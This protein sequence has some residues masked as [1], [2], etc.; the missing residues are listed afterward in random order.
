MPT[1]LTSHDSLNQTGQRLPQVQT[2][3]DELG[4]AIEALEKA[5]E[6][7]AVRY[8]TVM[9]EVGPQL[10]VPDPK[11]DL[12]SLVIVAENIREKSQKIKLL[13]ETVQSLEQRAEI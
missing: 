3:L 11:K 12:R 6:S 9:R 2:E 10:E 1:Y 8:S 7:L 13:I 5:I 4:F